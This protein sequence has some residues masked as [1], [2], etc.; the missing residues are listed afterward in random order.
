M[1]S[2]RQDSEASGGRYRVGARNERHAM[3]ILQNAIGFGS[4]RILYEDT[5]PKPSHILSMGICRKEMP[6][7]TLAPVRHALHR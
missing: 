1:T 5:D 2:V 4:I 7:Q 3:S 6:G